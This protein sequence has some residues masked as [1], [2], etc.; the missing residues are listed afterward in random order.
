MVPIENE[1]N[2]KEFRKCGGKKGDEKDAR[3][4][5][6]EDGPDRPK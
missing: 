2:E 1:W 4:T 3:K 5:E 6:S